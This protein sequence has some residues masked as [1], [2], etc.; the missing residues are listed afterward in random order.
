MRLLIATIAHK[1]PD[2]LELQYRNFQSHIPCNWD[3]LVINN[4]VDNAEQ[5]HQI[6][7]VARARNLLVHEMPFGIP[8]ADPVPACAIPMN[9]LFQVA[10]KLSG[11]DALC[12]ID[13]DMFFVS[14]LN[15]DAVMKGKPFSFVPQYRHDCQTYYPWNGLVFL[16]W[17]FLQQ[18]DFDWMPLPG[19]DVGGSLNTLLARNAPDAFSFLEMWNIYDLTPGPTRDYFTHLNGNLKVRFTRDPKDAFTIYEFDQRMISNTR[20]FPYEREQRNYLEYYVRNILKVEEFMH[21]YQL[22]FPRPTY[23]DLLSYDSF[24]SEKDFFVFHY[25]SGSNYQPWATAEYNELKTR[26]LEKLLSACARPAASNGKT[27]AGAQLA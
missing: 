4:A 14:S 9:A 7:A 16:T 17:D 27:I 26:E 19:T 11:Y 3:F 1:R 18:N 6:N 5:F 15:L 21:H 23:F 8:Y 20:C 24:E 12:V 10:K 2:F 13:S 22:A 25:K